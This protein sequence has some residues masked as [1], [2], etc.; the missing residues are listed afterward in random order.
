MPITPCHA[1][2]TVEAGTKKHSSSSRFP[3][4]EGRIMCG[5]QGWFRAPGDGSGN[6]W[7]H[8]GA[9]GRFDPDHCTIDLWPDVSEYEKTYPTGFRQG[10]GSPARVFSSRDASTIDRHFRWMKDYGIDGVFMQRFFDVT[11]NEHS[12]REGRVILSNALKSSQT[13]GRAIAVMYDLSGLNPGEDCSS[14]IADWKELVDELKLTSQGDDQTYLYHRGKPLVAIWGLGF[15]DRPYDIRDI[16]FQELLDFLKN[17]PEY[18]GCS[19]MLGVPTYFR[20]L[21]NDCTPDP[22]L[23]ELIE[24]ADIVMP[25]MVQR[26]TSLLHNEFQRYGEHIRQDIAWCKSRNVDYVPC[27][28]PGFSWHNLSRHDFGGRHPLDQNPRQKGAFYWGLLSQ[29]IKSNAQMIY[30]AMFDEVDEGTA[31]FKCTNHPPIDQ[32]PSRFLTYEGLPNDH[33]LWLTGKA[34]E[35][36]RGELALDENLYQQTDH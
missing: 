2:P 12:R 32:P 30:V 33:Y 28:Y 3:S 7:G 4:Y 14:V 27:V 35:T 16:G 13:H 26:F 19:V 36:L 5:Y 21:Y 11:R 6:R 1:T 24:Q 31:I 23:H 18:G 9:Q 20:E 15:P 29:A 10:D 17:D 22:F 25:W 34:G 8:Y